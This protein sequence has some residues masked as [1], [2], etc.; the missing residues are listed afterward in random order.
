MPSHLV[1]NLLAGL[2]VFLSANLTRDAFRVSL[3]GM[4]LLLLVGVAVLLAFDYSTLT[5][6]IYQ[7][8]FGTVVLAAYFGAGL[9]LAVIAAHLEEDYPALPRLLTILLAALPWLFILISVFPLDW[10]IRNQ[11]ALV[12]LML[13]GISLALI[14]RSLQLAFIR[15]RKRTFIITL[16]ASLAVISFGWKNAYFPSLLAEYDPTS[17]AEAPSIDVEQVMFAQPQLMQQK[18]ADLADGDPR[19]SEFY[20]VGFG[21]SNSETVFAT[22]TAFAEKLIDERHDTQSRSVRLFNDA[23]ALDIEP[24]ANTFNLGHT[25]RRIGQHMNTDDDVLFLLLSS[26]GSQSAEIDVQLDALPLRDLNAGDVREY[27]E[28]A[29]IK[30]RII[31]I[32]ACYS[33]SFIDYLADEYTVLI[34]ASDAQQPSFGCSSDRELTVFGDAYFNNSLTPDVDYVQAF[35]RAHALVKTWETERE[36]EFSNPQIRVGKKIA[37]KLAL[38]QPQTGQAPIP[39]NDPSTNQVNDK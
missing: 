18:L 3:P 14:I 32:S 29:N 2:R 26:H 23:S 38:S 27:L 12:P 30:W 11:A 6:V 8:T 25:L 4:L 39:V 16:L 20:F 21:G 10:S 22:E 13:L 33:G 17:F 36:L 24:I 37:E 31:V 35:D 9:L 5:H 7:D 1:H 15:P 34:T 19:L 28:E